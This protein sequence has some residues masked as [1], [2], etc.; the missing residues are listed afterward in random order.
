[1]R[2]LSCLLIVCLIASCASF[3]PYNGMVFDDFRHQAGLAGRGGAE[4]VGKNGT[5]SVYFLNGLGDQRTFYWFEDGIL[6][7]VTQSTVASVKHQLKAMYKPAHLKARKSKKKASRQT[8]VD[9]AGSGS[10]SAG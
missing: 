3:D 5:T 1:L 2:K 8:S 7:K 4:L 9:G 6:R 10:A